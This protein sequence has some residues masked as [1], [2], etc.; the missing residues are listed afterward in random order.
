MADYDRK[1]P[2]APLSSSLRALSEQAVRELA[3]ENS[4]LWVTRGEKD[5]TVHLHFGNDGWRR[6]T[7]VEP[8][9]RS[10]AVNCRTASFTLDL[11]SKQ[12]REEWT[13][14]LQRSRPGT[15]VTVVQFPWHISPENEAESI[16]KIETWLRRVDVAAA[17]LK[18]EAPENWMLT[19]AEFPE[20][21]Y[22]TR[23]RLRGGTVE[24]GFDLQKLNS[25][26]SSGYRNFRIRVSKDGRI[27]V[28]GD[29]D[30]RRLHW[31]TSEEWIRPTR[32]YERL[33]IAAIREALTM[34]DPELVE[35]TERVAPA[36]ETYQLVHSS[37]GF[38]QLI[39][40]APL[41]AQRL[42]QL[43]KEGKLAD[44]SRSDTRHNRSMRRMNEMMEHPLRELITAATISRQRWWRQSSETRFPK[45]ESEFDPAP[46]SLVAYVRHPLSEIAESGRKYG[47]LFGHSTIE[48]LKAANTDRVRNL[49]D[50][51][52][53]ALVRSSLNYEKV[54]AQ[55][56]FQNP[57]AAERAIEEYFP[58]NIRELFEEDDIDI[59]GRV[60]REMSDYLHRDREAS[61]ITAQAA[62][63]PELLPSFRR[64]SV[65]SKEW[66]RELRHRAI[67]EV[68]DVTVDDGQIFAP[69]S[70]DGLKIGRYR[71]LQ[72]RTSRALNLEGRRMGHCVGGGYYAEKCLKGNSVIFSVEMEME[73]GEWTGVAT[74][75]LS[76]NYSRLQ[77][78]GRDSFLLG[79]DFRLKLDALL[80]KRKPRKP[81]MSR[82][83]WLVAQAKRREARKVKLQ[84]KAAAALS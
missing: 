37:I 60:L 4:G 65:E 62:Q 46:A 14:K 63:R 52:A 71:L 31:K 51:K 83:E 80:L 64:L 36:I 78:Q 66:H 72:L 75:E 3:A 7:Q 57:E 74:L 43:A 40:T 81:Y 34:L 28:L 39:D 82:A 8:R 12:Y 79:K 73:P 6:Q 10:V 18:R 26:F 42:A 9:L 24:I 11:P 61:Q 29:A 56:V 15:K 68:K 41:I 32:M 58:A 55:K 49:R 77:L 13:L 16:P 50:P 1:L 47:D 22:L 23:R 5:E 48:F 20:N 30:G 33:R 27:R 35:K 76:K 67:Q 54:L 53:W 25:D 45:G 70:L 59:T 44:G 69:C 2:L 21:H 19:K 17:V 84:E 38:R